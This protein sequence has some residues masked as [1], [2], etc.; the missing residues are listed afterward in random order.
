MKRLP[1]GA[2]LERIVVER[3]NDENPAKSAHFSANV[4]FFPAKSADF[5]A[6]FDS[7]PAKSVD[8]SANLPLK[9]PRNFDFFSQ[10]IRSPAVGTIS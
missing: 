5:S 8:F 6:N 9:I 3:A 10:N 1:I 2:F 7:F 4:D